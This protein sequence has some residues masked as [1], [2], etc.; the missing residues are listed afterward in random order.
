MGGLT[1]TV[2]THGVQRM[3]PGN[4]RG[5]TGLIHQLHKPLT[6]AGVCKTLGNVYYKLALIR[7]ES[8]SE[9]ILRGG[10]AWV[11]LLYMLFHTDGK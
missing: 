7:K 2:I 9:R 6:Y 8:H 1:L 3:H 11:N 5:D 10:Q 4:V